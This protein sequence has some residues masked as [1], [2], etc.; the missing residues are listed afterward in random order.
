MKT[1][2]KNEEITTS[3]EQSSKSQLTIT[4]TKPIFKGDATFSQ[5]YLIDSNGTIKVTND[6]KQIKGSIPT[7]INLEINYDYLNK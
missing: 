1:A 6:F 5:T 2:G 4:F 7:S 3:I